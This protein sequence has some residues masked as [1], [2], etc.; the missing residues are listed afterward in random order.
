MVVGGIVAFILDNL[1]P[2][3]AQDRGI[4]KWRSLMVEE[5]KG[6]MASI[7]VYDLPFGVTNHRT[8]KNRVSPVSRA[9][10]AHMNSP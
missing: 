4:V 2:G 6:T 9:S 8:R 3:S 1:L 5:G 7:H 10:P